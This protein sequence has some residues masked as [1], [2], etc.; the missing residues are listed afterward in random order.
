MRIIIG[1]FLLIG[2]E[3]FSQTGPSQP[4]NGPGGSEYLCASFDSA[5]YGTNLKEWCW[6][7]EPKT[8]KLDTAPVIVYWHGYYGGL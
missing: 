6:I 1:F 2:V 5:F 7:Y 3:L 4:A 8:P